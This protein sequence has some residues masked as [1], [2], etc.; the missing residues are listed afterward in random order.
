MEA[1]SAVCGH[2]AGGRAELFNLLEDPH[3]RQD[4][5]AHEP[6]RVTALTE[7]INRWWTP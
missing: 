1:D 3:E 5:A 7:Q 2:G 6:G 4:L